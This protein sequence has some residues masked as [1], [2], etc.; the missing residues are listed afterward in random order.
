VAND[1]KLVRVNHSPR[2]LVLAAAGKDKRSE[3]K[4]P[5]RHSWLGHLS[6]SSFKPVSVTSSCS[7]VVRLA[8]LSFLVGVSTVGLSAPGSAQG[9]GPEGLGGLIDALRTLEDRGAFPGIGDTGAVLDGVRQRA[10]EQAD[11]R[12]QEA[13]ENK[14]TLSRLERTVA[15]AFCDGTLPEKDRDIIDSIEEFSPLERDYC[16]RARELLLQVGY[17]IFGGRFGPEALLNGAAPK[18]FR[19]GI[20]DELIITLVG[21]QTTTSEFNV[22]REGRISVSTLPPIPA[23]GL[24]LDEFRRELNA[25]ASEAFIGTE[26]FVSL[27]SVRAIS[28][29][30]SG[31]VA[32]PGLQQATALSTIIDALGLAGGVKK[33][34]SLRRIEVHRGDS[35]RWVDLYDLVL[36]RGGV[37]DLSLEEGDRI[38]VPPIG[39]TIAVAGEVKR[40]GIFELAEGQEHADYPE[41]VQFSGGTIRPRGIALRRIS[42]DHR[43]LEQIERVAERDLVA[44]DGDL[45]VASKQTNS[46]VGGV[47]LV[48]H[49]S[50]PGIRSLAQTPTTASLLGGKESLD[51][52]PYL[53]LGVLETED[54]ST[55]ARRYFAL[56]LISILRGT[57]DYELRDGDRL[58]VLSQDDVAFLSSFEV[59]SII[60]VPFSEPE[61][62]GEGPR[63]NST[64]RTSDGVGTT[65]GTLEELAARVS[66]ERGGDSANQ[67]QVESLAG[68]VV[69]EPTSQ[70]RSL[71]ALRKLVSESRTGRFANATIGQRDR[72]EQ[73]PNKKPECRAVYED[74]AGLLSFLLEHGTAVTGEVRSP[75]IYPTAAPTPLS[76][77]VGV[78]GGMTRE[79]D[80]TRVH[81]SRY[82][83][84]SETGSATISSEELNANELGLG[85]IMVSAGDVVR[86]NA[87]FTDRDTGPVFLVGEFVRPGAYEIRRGERLSQIISRAGGLTAQAYPYGALFTRE[88]V[89]RA[90]EASLRRL[91]RELNSAVTVAAANRGIDASAISSFAALTREVATAP[92]S[93]RVVIEADPTVL[94]VRPELD[95]VLE[96]GDRLYMP[97]RPNSVLVTGDVLN[98]GA[99]QFVSGKSVET[100]IRQAGGFQR[101]ADRNRLFVVLPD[102][103]AQPVS[104][105]PFNYTPVR[106]PP[107]SA[108]VVPK[109][110]TP[111]DIFTVTRE[112]ASLV[113]QLAITAASLAVI[114]DN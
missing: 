94:D 97:K 24:T 20:G 15:R 30:V 107:G 87:V 19:L 40:P 72:S 43:G 23:A 1:G 51:V 7:A 50:V 6:M 58:I 89:K 68:R 48:G 114:S 55:Q 67:S 70:C 52:D 66:A 49:V 74:N 27:G 64:D 54:P 22:D 14:V 75:G 81:V 95:I 105:S 47:E 104:V 88:R 80:L 3:H 42:F 61:D 2:Q 26:A 9:L 96:P 38:V 34:G 98:P 41:I 102:G 16:L 91:A 36:G 4:M 28:V 8:F 73:R 92:A 85:Q 103:S 11:E 35:I 90:E 79:V 101:S 18:N 69:D 59:Q 33:T 93:G 86:F 71:A 31:E 17:E 63:Q 44:S 21:Q 113:S 83:V 53:L 12:V 106:V 25:R 82:T 112:V 57:V 45:I 109:D 32:R 84:E 65:V 5:T 46:Q 29:L 111:F 39:P 99:M 13:P 100:Y 108:I 76:S 62:E 110:A 37:P 56:D 60:F 77:I 10:L 78:A